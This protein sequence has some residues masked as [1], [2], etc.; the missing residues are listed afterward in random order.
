MM[1]SGTATLLMILIWILLPIPFVLMR[2]PAGA[3]RFGEVGRPMDFM[4]A[5]SAFF[6]NYFNFSGRASRSEFWWAILFLFIVNTIVSF[7]PLLGAVWTLGIFFPSIALAARRLHDINRS[8]WFQL[9]SCLF[10]IGTIA[11]IVWYCTAPRDAAA[12]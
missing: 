1:E 9:L 11:L 3:N 6:S 10:P 4:Q 7:I 5:V 2:V 12:G 8:G